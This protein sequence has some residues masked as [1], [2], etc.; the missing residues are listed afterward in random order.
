M[1]SKSLEV[2]WDS[3]SQSESSFG[4]VRVHSFT[5]SYTLGSMKCDSRASFLAC[6]FVSPCFGYEPKVKVVTWHHHK[7]K[8]RLFW[9]SMINVGWK[10]TM[11]NET[12]DKF[13]TFDGMLWTNLQLMP[14]L[15]WLYFITLSQFHFNFAKM[16]FV[17][18]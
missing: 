14:N 17:L 7:S 4:S 15:V 6:T 11:L 8:I 9:W 16:L 5:L 10:N 1:P 13:E 12:F 18:N 2:H 3:N